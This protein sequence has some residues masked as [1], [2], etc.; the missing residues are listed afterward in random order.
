MVRLP[1][2]LRPLVPRQW[3]HGAKPKPGEVPL[4]GDPGIRNRNQLDQR[5]DRRMRLPHMG[6]QRRVG[7]TRHAT[8]ALLGEHAMPAQ[9]PFDA[10][11]VVAVIAGDVND[12]LLLD[13]PKNRAKIAPPVAVT[14][15]CSAA[16]GE[17]RRYGLASTPKR[18]LVTSF[19]LFTCK[20]SRCFSSVSSWAFTSETAS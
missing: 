9:T 16:D 1:G 3:P 10:V 15:R 19:V 6:Y 12:L 4:P 7:R 5:G 13:D 18:Y 2:E 11:V 20:S 17:R 14:P 8:P